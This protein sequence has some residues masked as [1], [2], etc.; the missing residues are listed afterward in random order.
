MRKSLHSASRVNDLENL[1][2]Q[3]R[4]LAIV[5]CEAERIDKYRAKVIIHK[6]FAT[7]EI[8]VS[9][10]TDTAFQYKSTV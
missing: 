3:N 2:I 1:S 9:L 10:T 6:P 4:F 8:M 5:A 7:Y